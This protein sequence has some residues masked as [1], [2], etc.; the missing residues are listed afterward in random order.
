MIFSE[1][2]NGEN[3]CRGFLT[4]RMLLL[5]TCFLSAVILC[6]AVVVMVIAS[7]YSDLI[8]GPNDGNVDRSI[9]SILSMNITGG[10]DKLCDADMPTDVPSNLDVDGTTLNLKGVGLRQARKF[11]ITVDVYVAA[12]YTN[13]PSFDP[14]QLINSDSYK[15]I[16]M[17]FVRDID[18]DALIGS[19]E[20]ERGLKE[21]GISD[22]KQVLEASGLHTVFTDVKKGQKVSIQ[23]VGNKMNFLVDDDLKFSHIDKAFVKAVLGVYLLTPPDDDLPEALLSGTPADC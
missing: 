18:K 13:D 7:N 22:V 11:R 17:Y 3:V 15:Q 6:S 21:Q 20:W 1:K 2:K 5:V 12:F 4:K 9:S 10:S 23:L 14:H 8:C 16:D 19:W